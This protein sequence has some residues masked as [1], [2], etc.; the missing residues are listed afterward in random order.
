MKIKIA[1][2]SLKKS[3]SWMTKKFPHTPIQ[4]IPKIQLT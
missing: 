1:S 4:Q 2:Y 3:P